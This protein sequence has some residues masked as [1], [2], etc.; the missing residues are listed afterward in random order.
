MILAR[1]KKGL[2]LVT[3]EV[4][5]MDKNFIVNLIG[6][7]NSLLLKTGICTWEK[8]EY[9]SIDK[10]QFQ[11]QSNLQDDLLLALQF[12]NLIIRQFI[13]SLKILNLDQN[14]TIET[15]NIALSHANNI[16][17]QSV[18]IRLELLDYIKKHENILQTELWLYE[19]INNLS[20]LSG[21]LQSLIRKHNGVT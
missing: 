6:N 21:F 20:N 18:D 10:W 17:Q 11:Q 8:I 19:I 9:S 7:L 1:I 13:E 16:I 5:Q 2:K 14:I 15:H 3:N 12:T 4:S